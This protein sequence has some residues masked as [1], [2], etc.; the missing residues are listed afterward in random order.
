[1]AEGGATVVTNPVANLRLAVGRVFPYGAARRHGVAVGLGTDGA[2]SNNSLDLIADMKTFALIQKHEARDAAAIPAA[3]VWDVATG[4]R[5]PVLRGSR[6][7]VGEPAD[8]L[9]LRADTP[10]LG[11]GDF[12]ADLV[13]AA[14]GSIV[15]T[16]V[17]DGRA[18][19]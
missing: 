7:G 17:V 5:A 3:E 6:L 12:V 2:G 11:I 16:T 13:Y 9:L 10:E 15:D 14:S 8:F 18:L 1:I 4:V 19:M